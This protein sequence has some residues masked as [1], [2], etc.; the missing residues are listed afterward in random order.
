MSFSKYVEGTNMTINII[1]VPLFLGCDRPGVEKGPD[2]LRNNK[3]L[4]IFEDTGHEIYDLGNI[5]VPKLPIEDNT[6]I[7]II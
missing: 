4:N 5:Y 7:I 3:I 1:G 6:A 2:T